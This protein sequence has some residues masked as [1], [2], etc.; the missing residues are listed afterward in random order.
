MNPT[1]ILFEKHLKELGLWFRPEVKFHPH[2]KWRVDYMVSLGD[3]EEAPYYA[4]EIDGG[5]YTQGRH[6]RGT[7]RQMDMDK[8][9]HATVLGYRVLTFSTQDVL[10]GRAKDFLKLHLIERKS[11]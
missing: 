6:T 10:R 2:R 8:L 4:I 1:H 5:I 3:S 9:N 7:G 11:P